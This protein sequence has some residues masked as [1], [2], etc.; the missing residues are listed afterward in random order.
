MPTYSTSG[1][2]GGYLAAQGVY[3]DVIFYSW[4]VSEPMTPVGTRNLVSGAFAFN[5]IVGLHTDNPL[6]F[7]NL[8]L[9]FT[10]I[11]GTYQST[12]ECLTFRQKNNRFNI[13]NMRFWLPSGTALNSSGH[14]EWAASGQWVYN[15]HIPSGNGA[16]LSS[17]LPILANVR[18]QDGL[19]YID[20]SDDTHVSEFIY[21]V[22]TVPSGL[23]LGRYGP[24]N[25]NGALAFNMTYDWFQII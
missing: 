1:N 10:A 21:L 4:N 22:L 11:S 2:I 14:L 25:S 17:S 18:R 20:G 16:T 7:R 12:V 13:S 15:A 23:P 6:E 24:N 5:K 19:G 8:I 9:D 3:P